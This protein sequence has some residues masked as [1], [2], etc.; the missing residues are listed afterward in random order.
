MKK[1]V[2]LL[3]L[4]IATVAACAPT[5]DPTSAP[6]LDPTTSEPTSEAPV[7]GKLYIKN[8][9]QYLSYNPTRIKK[10]MDKV[11]TPDLDLYYF[12]VDES[13]AKIENDYIIPLKVGETQV[14]ASTITGQEVEF[15]IN[16]QD[17]E[18][19]IYHRDVNSAV[20]AF[21]TRAGNPQN[22]TL[23]IGDSFFDVNNF[24][25]NFYTDFEGYPVAS[26]GI[27][28]SQTTHQMIA[29][30][31]LIKQFNPKNI[32]MHIGTND[33]N[34]TT[35]ALNSDQYYAQ[36]TEYLSTICSEYP[37]VNIYYLGIENRNAGA[38][39]KNAYAE[40]VTAK[41]QNEFAPEHSNFTY[42][43]SPSV[44][45]TDLNKYLSSDNIHPSEE[46]R[47]WYIKTLKEIV[48]W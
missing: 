38:G 10:M 12:I 20:E 47:Q 13:I 18:N 5:S 27:S 24:W 34:D 2:F 33:I 30:D 43:D 16:V 37:E 6:T 8:Y 11:E 7:E 40:K 41:I 9:V 25:N 31:R 48:E 35:L 32:V 14:F 4:V 21:S 22:P 19:F 28:G 45:N 42:I 39:S 44:F 36:I 1:I 17:D 15:T 23:F 26:M 3:P 29:R 46:G